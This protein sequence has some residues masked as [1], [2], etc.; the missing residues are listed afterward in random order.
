MCAVRAVTNSTQSDNSIRYLALASRSILDKLESLIIELEPIVSCQRG[1]DVRKLY[2]EKRVINYNLAR[3]LSAGSC[4]YGR[5]FAFRFLQ[6]HLT[7]TPCGSA[8]VDA[9]ISVKY[10]ST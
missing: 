10:L 6:L 5:G 8:T 9:I 2:R 1:F 4:S 3:G 7:A